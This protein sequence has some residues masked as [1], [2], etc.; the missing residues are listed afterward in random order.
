V[1]DILSWLNS[2][3]YDGLPYSIVTLSFTLTFKYLRFP[4]VTCAGTFV[5]GAAVA[6]ILTVDFGLNPYAST[7]FAFLAA[8][9]GGLLTV[10]FHVILRIETLLAGILSAFSIYAVNLLLLHPTLPYGLAET[11]LSSSERLDRALEW[12]NLAWH[13]FSILYFF[14]VAILVKLALDSFYASEVGLAIRALE[15]GTSGEFA[16]ERVGLSP[17]IYKGLG[18]IVGNGLVGFSG[19]IVSMKEGAAN[20]HRGF[21]VLITGLIAFLIGIQIQRGLASGFDWLANWRY[22]SRLGRFRRL[23]RVDSTTAAILG[24]VLY[25]GLIAF[26]QASEIQPEL[27]KL[28]LAVYVALAIGD[29]GRIRRSLRRLFRANSSKGETESQEKPPSDMGHLI[30]LSGIHF[31]YP[32]GVQEI[33]RGVD[34]Q[35]GRGELIALEGRNGCGKTTLLR[36]ISGFL[37]HPDQ[38]TIIFNGKDVTDSPAARRSSVGYLDQRPEWGL[39]SPFTVEENVALSQIRGLNPFR[40]ALTEGRR[41]VIRA[42]FT[43]AGFFDEFLG[44]TTRELSGGQRQIVK[45]LCLAGTKDERS[46]ILL[47]E[48]LNNLDQDNARKCREI[49]EQFRR[50]GLSIVLVSHLD[51][52][53]YGVDRVVNLE[54]INPSEGGL[55]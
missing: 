20:A 28:L 13:P 19:A 21:D 18:L 14:A 12:G 39:V 48:P 7:V 26:S 42:L 2:T 49:I 8:A 1:L 25:F 5:L 31:R 52:Q 37:T 11:L 22:F 51:S 24:A 27:T 15:D 32:G 36:L 23:S 38:G 50:E 6:A 53:Q 44:R 33:L 46:V 16:L 43:S 40:K 29:L 9:G 17:A 54:S 35:I 41:R 3:L 47:D 30:R 34:F 4:D 10:V 55:S 45:V